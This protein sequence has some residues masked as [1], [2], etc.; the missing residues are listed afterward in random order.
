[1][2]KKKHYFYD[3]PISPNREQ[4]YICKLLKKYTNMPATEELKKQIWEELQ[5]EKFLG[6]ITIPFKIVLRKD[7]YGKYPDTIEIILDTKV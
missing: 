1:M 4:G 2:S 5:K 7:I 6:N 3:K